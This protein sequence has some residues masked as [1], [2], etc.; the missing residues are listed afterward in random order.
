MS[1]ADRERWDA[2]WR[3][4]SHDLSAPEPFLVEHARLLRPGPVLDVAAG[5]GRNALFLATRGHAVTAVDVSPEALRLLA[6]RARRAG[7]EIAV[8][9][10]D[11]DD[12]RALSGLGPFADAVVIRYRPSEEQWERILGVLAPGARLLICTFAPEDHARHGTRREHCLDPA[13]L[14]R[15]FAGRLRPLLAETFEQGGRVLTGSVWED[16][17]E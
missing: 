12:P 7:A 5:A 9:C 11:L 4:R 8:R 10:A 3:A 2:R 6:E 16:V 1:L 17:R 14:E 13:E 15:L